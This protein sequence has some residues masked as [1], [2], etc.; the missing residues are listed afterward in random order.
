MSDTPPEPQPSE[1]AAPAAAEPPPP[2]EPPSKGIRWWPPFAIVA[3]GAAISAFAHVRYAEEMTWRHPFIM[4]GGFV[5]P[6]FFLTLWWFFFSRARWKT[7]FQIAA[8][9]V[10][11]LV[12][13]LT[14][15]RFTGLSGAIR[16]QFEPRFRL[17]LS[18]SFPWI[19]TYIPSA[20]EKLEAF[21]ASSRSDGTAVPT[22]DESVPDWPGFRGPLRDGI[23]RGVEIRTDWNANPPKRV[24]GHAVGDAWSSFAVVDGLLYTQEQRGD[25][26]EFEAVVCYDANTGEQIWEHRNEARFYDAQGG[27]G[28][29]AT[30]TLYEGRL[31]ALGGTGILD[32]LDPLTGDEHWTT[33]VLE[34]AG[35]ENIAWGMSASPLVYDDVVV[36]N[37]GRN[38]DN[39]KYGVAAYD[40]MTGDVKWTAGTSKAGYSA[41]RLETI[42]GVRQVLV[43]DADGLAGYEA[44]YGEQLWQFPW[45]TFSDVNV[46]QPIV[47]DEKHVF[48]ASGYSGSFKNG[49]ALLSVMRGDDG[50]WNVEKQ[51]ELPTRFK[52][53]F[54]SAV[55]KDGYLYGLDDGI[56]AC[57]D[58]ATGERI[59]KDRDGTYGF[60]QLLLVGDHVLTTVEKTGEVA[61]VRASPDGF[62][63]VGRFQALNVEG[64]HTGIT[65]N[66]PVVWNGLLFV[67]GA[68]EVAC[69]DLRQ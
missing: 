36:V 58:Y 45:K 66:H 42:D 48:L 62:E 39:G 38:G 59:W 67:R 19:V 28:P 2:V 68:T 40:R 34:D 51:Y 3:V 41:P 31:Y 65:W 33:N 64:E 16:P 32:C 53:K 57:H 55:Y 29:R 4:I 49:C 8:V 23:V 61:L 44:D 27:P 69:Y 10:V 25:A 18:G 30:P 24:W 46:A 5:A 47:K 54:Q 56:M 52:L 60:G 37:P 14:W 63:E 20:S 13:F 43:F 21:V 7:K 11:L 35:S 9:P 17:G 50:N 15:N 26:G 6:A 12:G 1:E 22:E